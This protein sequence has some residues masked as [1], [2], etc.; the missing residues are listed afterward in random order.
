V[1]Q[2]LQPIQYISEKVFQNSPVWTQF[3]ISV[4]IFRNLKICTEIRFFLGFGW[5]DLAADL[6]IAD[7][8]I[9]VGGAREGQSFILK[10]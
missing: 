1:F 4:G 7:R 8:A 6:D 3:Q 2:S 5:Q 10:V 9:Q